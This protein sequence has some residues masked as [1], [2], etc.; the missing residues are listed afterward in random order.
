MSDKRP[1]AGTGVRALS[2]LFV[3]ALALFPPVPRAHSQVADRAGSSVAPPLPSPIV[4][5]ALRAVGEALRPGAAARAGFSA[6]AAPAVPDPAATFIDLDAL[7]RR[8]TAAALREAA[9]SFDISQERMVA[10][11]QKAGRENIGELPWATIAAVKELRASIAANAEERVAVAAGRLVGLVVR[12]ALPASVTRVRSSATSSSL[13]LG[14]VGWQQLELSAAAE[15]IGFE[16]RVHPSRVVPVDDPSA[17]VRAHLLASHELAM[18]LAFGSAERELPGGERAV[19][20]LRARLERAVILSAGLIEWARQGAAGSAPAAGERAEA[21][22]AASATEA[23]DEPSEPGPD[24]AAR[25][26]SRGSKVFHRRDCPHA[27]RISPAN[28][29]TF[30]S[31]ATAVNKGLRPCKTCAP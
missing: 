4:E 13:P 22:E 29:R 14:L 18:D 30:P 7:A 6:A 10:R 19:N 27:Q 23:R 16:L 8:E 1:H 12:G 5:G 2:T 15:R 17:A 3:C 24:D 25:V 28:Q 21:G 9:T 20:L 11:A 31:R 26:A